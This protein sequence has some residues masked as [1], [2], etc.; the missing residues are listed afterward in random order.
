MN[1]LLPLLLLAMTPGWAQDGE[2]SLDNAP[3]SVGG[4]AKSC[5]EGIKAPAGKFCDSKDECRQ[6]CSCACVFDATKWGVKGQQDTTCAG[7]PATGP[8]MLDGADLPKIPALDYVTG[9]AGKRASQAVIDALKRLDVSLEDS[10]NRKKWGY[11]VRVGSCHRSHIADTKR[12]C[13]IVLAS[14]YML[15]NKKYKD[16]NERQHWEDWL[17]PNQAGLSWPGNTPHSSGVA[18]DLLLVNSEGKDCH[19]CKA[20]VKGAPSCELIDQS[21]KSI[22]MTDLKKI[23]RMLDEE[24][25]KVGAYRLSYEAWHYEWRDDPPK[26]RCKAADCSKWPIS[27]SP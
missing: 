20:G 15:D 6:F 19:G 27:C 21:D 13:S 18:C 2:L 22:K 3:A 14:M 23:H 4:A 26:N 5:T 17:D 24:L 1:P 7:I 10:T 11:T 8:G 25:D 16:E 12:E 9:G